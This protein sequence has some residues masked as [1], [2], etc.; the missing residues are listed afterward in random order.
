MNSEIDVALNCIVEN[1]FAKSCESFR[2]CTMQEMEIIRIIFKLDSLPKSYIDL[3]MVLGKS[4]IEFLIGSRFYYTDVLTNRN[5]LKDLLEEDGADVKIIDNA[6]VFFGH[7]GYIYNF[8]YSDDRSERIYS[9]G[10]GDMRPIFV[11]HGLF[12]WIVSVVDDMVR[13]EKSIQF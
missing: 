8:M 13:F 12:N 9:Y 2:G 6:V 5:G 3:M 7:Q 11:Q 10:E 1:G 4:K